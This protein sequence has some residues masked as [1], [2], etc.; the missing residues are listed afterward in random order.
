ML[1]KKFLDCLLTAVRRMDW[2]H[3]VFFF[4]SQV[5]TRREYKRGYEVAIRRRYTIYKL[6]NY[7]IQ[8]VS[9]E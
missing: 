6:H 9:R 8:N 1:H 3:N 4:T 2:L 7:F 5:S